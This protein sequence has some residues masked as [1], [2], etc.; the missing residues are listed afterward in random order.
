MKKLLLLTS[1]FLSALTVLPAQ[2][3]LKPQTTIDDFDGSKRVLMDLGKLYCKR[4]T[5]DCPSIGMLWSSTAPNDLLIIAELRDYAGEKYFSIQSMQFNI[6]GEITTI[7]PINA[8]TTREK[9]SIGSRS[10]QGFNTNIDFLSILNSAHDVKVRVVTD[11]GNIDG[12]FKQSGLKYGPGKE[13]FSAYLEELNKNN[14][15]Y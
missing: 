8:F 10:I 5:Q 11:K 14:V 2:A 1:I 15:Q 7:K 9:D 13:N 3:K 4:V 12:I 6:D